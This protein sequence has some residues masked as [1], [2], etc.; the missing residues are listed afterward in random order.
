M[1]SVPPSEA[2]RWPDPV[3]PPLP[4]RMLT[5]QGIREALAL[6]VRHSREPE[7]PAFDVTT[8]GA[9]GAAQVALIECADALRM[10]EQALSGRLDFSQSFIDSRISEAVI[11]RR[12][13]Y[14]VIDNLRRWLPL[15][16][17]ERSAGVTAPNPP[18]VGRG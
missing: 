3:R 1:V 16:Y 9:L 17:A 4:S 18:E 13:A 10:E 11:A 7:D 8:F 15:T 6:I 12:I 14:R 2:S 5:E